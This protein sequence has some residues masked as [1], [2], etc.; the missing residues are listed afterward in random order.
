VGSMAVQGDLGIRADGA[1]LLDELFVLGVYR[2]FD[3]VKG[4]ASI[5]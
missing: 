1:E 4:G 5:I 3:R 2:G